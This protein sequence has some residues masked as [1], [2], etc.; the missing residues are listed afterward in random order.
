[1]ETKRCQCGKWFNAV[2]GRDPDRC[3]LCVIG[4]GPTAIRKSD[5]IMRPWWP[6]TPV[7]PPAKSRPTTKKKPASRET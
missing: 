4:H 3:K 2:E 1:M 5:R 7:Q 6:E